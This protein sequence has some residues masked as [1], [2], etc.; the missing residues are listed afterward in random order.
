MQS[1]ADIYYV[2]SITTLILSAVF[3]HT[4]K[5]PQ[6]FP[7]PLPAQETSTHPSLIFVLVPKRREGA[8]LVRNDVLALAG[9]R[10]DQD[11]ELL[12]RD[13]EP[14]V[15]GRLDIVIHHGPVPAPGREVKG[16][17]DLGHV[18]HE[19]V[20]GEPLA[21]A[22]PPPGAEG[23][24]G[25]PVVFRGRVHGRAR[26]ELVAHEPVG[27]EVPRPLVLR[28]VVVDGPRVGHHDRALGQEVALVRVVPGE[29]VRDAAWCYRSPS[30]GLKG[31]RKKRKLLVS[32]ASGAMPGA[33]PAYDR[34][35]GTYFVHAGLDER[36][37]PNVFRRWRSR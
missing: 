15:V 1:Q 29:G 18:Q 7:L 20:P 24:R 25:P 4:S 32:G 35:R 34:E 22:R 14:I 6:I 5:Q 11:R 33:L 13:Q 36:H 27:P 17:G 2:F 19:G 37:T 21:G 26:A 30:E 3:M 10:R 8:K 23:V 16:P 28:L 12:G 31:R 9:P